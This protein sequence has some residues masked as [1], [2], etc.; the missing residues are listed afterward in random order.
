MFW[1][2]VSGAAGGLL[3]TLNMSPKLDTEVT[4]P[5]HAQA[6][7]LSRPLRTS[8]H[9]AEARCDLILEVG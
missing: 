2:K 8:E 6:E 1:G 4:V 9:V 7:V 5:L 3:E